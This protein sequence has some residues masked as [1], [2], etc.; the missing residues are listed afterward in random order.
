MAK[1]Q[2]EQCINAIVTMTDPLAPAVTQPT[3]RDAIMNMVEQIRV[4]E[5]GGQQGEIPPGAV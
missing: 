4:R 2:K 3:P 5:K 1:S